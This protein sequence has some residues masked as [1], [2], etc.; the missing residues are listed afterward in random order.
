VTKGKFDPAITVPATFLGLGV[1]AAYALLS[2]YLGKGFAISV[3]ILGVAGG[4]A[5]MLGPV[6]KAI[7]HRI[8][9]GTDTGIPLEELDQIHARLGELDEMTAR[10]AELEER[11]DFTERL[12]AQHREPPRLAEGEREGHG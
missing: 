9:G 2:G 12:L 1:L 6:G 10:L 8:S 11:L 7:A 5:V 4:V 3:G